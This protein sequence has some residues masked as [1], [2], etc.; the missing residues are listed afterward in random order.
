MFGGEQ[1]SATYVRM[2]ECMHIHVYACTYISGN[3]HACAQMHMHEYIAKDGY[4]NWI[5]ATVAKQLLHTSVKVTT[6]SKKKSPCTRNI[7][8]FRFRLQAPGMLLVTP[9]SAG[10]HPFL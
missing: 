1:D 10:L 5:A 4:N 3:T 2:I 6:Y 9:W 8:P 7:F